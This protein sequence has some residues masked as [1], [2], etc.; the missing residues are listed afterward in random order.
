MAMK[1]LTFISPGLSRGGHR[2]SVSLCYHDNNKT[3]SY[4]AS[5]LVS[6]NKIDADYKSSKADKKADVGADCM[7]YRS[8]SSYSYD[9]TCYSCY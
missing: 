5:Y 8:V 3:I 2:N 4:E 6:V 1:W 7:L 9:G